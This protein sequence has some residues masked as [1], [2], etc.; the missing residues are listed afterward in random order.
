MH[1]FTKSEVISLAYDFNALPECVTDE[2]LHNLCQAVYDLGVYEAYRVVEGILRKD[3]VIDP[4]K[5]YQEQYNAG[6][7]S[8][9]QNIEK[10]LIEERK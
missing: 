1:K 2:T 7:M 6:I 5:E 10:I 8:Q 4:K 9:I 3:M